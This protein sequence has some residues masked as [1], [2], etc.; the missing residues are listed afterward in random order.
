MHPLL[1]LVIL[2]T[3]CCCFLCTD[4]ARTSPSNQETSEPSQGL[5]EANIVSSPSGHHQ[6]E[7][8]EART[9]VSVE[10]TELVAKAE[11]GTKTHV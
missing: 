8:E 9:D 3:S 10:F 11:E 7:E 5:Q 4:T 6:E 1:E 2:C